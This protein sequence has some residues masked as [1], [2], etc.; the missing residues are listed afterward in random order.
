MIR[1]ACA[2]EVYELFKSGYS[3]CLHVAFC[4]RHRDRTVFTI[5]KPIKSG[6]I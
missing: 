2:K 1:T 3:N 5:D 4:L 6:S